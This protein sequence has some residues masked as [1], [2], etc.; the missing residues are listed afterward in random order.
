MKDFGIACHPISKMPQ[1]L[2]ITSA[3]IISSSSNDH[4]SGRPDVCMFQE[5]AVVPIYTFLYRVF[6]LRAQWWFTRFIRHLVL[7]CTW[8][9]MYL[10]SCCPFAAAKECVIPV[11]L[12]HMFC[13]MYFTPCWALGFTNC[14]RTILW[15]SVFCTSQLVILCKYDLSCDY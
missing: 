8:G 7:K 13:L 11:F 15:N 9:M 6:L 3:S 4:M 1:M 10:I 5:P 2:I 14:N 12:S